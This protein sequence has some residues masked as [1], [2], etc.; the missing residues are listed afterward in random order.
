[1]GWRARGRDRC[2]LRRARDRGSV[3][4]GTEAPGRVPVR[5]RKNNLEAQAQDL[6]INGEHSSLALDWLHRARPQIDIVRRPETPETGK[7]PASGIYTSP[8]A[9]HA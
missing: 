9:A 5:A 6:L 3:W 4:S 8:E 2:E 1:V 7:W